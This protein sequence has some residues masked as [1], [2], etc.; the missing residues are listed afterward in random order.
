MYKS[1]RNL[2]MIKKVLLLVALMCGMTSMASCGNDNPAIGELKP[3]PEETP[4]DPENPVGP[5]TPSAPVD[6]MVVGY[7]PTYG[8]WFNPDWNKLTH[9][10]VAFAHM[11]ADGVLDCGDVRANKQIITKAHDNGV[12]VLIS[13]RDADN[14]TS[15][16]LAD[17]SKRAVLVDNVKQCVDEFGVEGVDVD[18][19]EW[20]GDEQAKRRNLESFYKELHAAL[21]KDKLVTAAVGGMTQTNN[22]IDAQ[23]LS[24]LDYVFPMI[25]DQCGGWAG[26]G[27]GSVG[28]HSSYEYYQ[29]VVNFFLGELNVPK[30][31]LCPGMPFYGYQFMSATSTKDAFAIA[32]RDILGKYS[33]AHLSDNK[34]LIWYNGLETIKKKTKYAVDNDLAGVMIWEITQDCDDTAKSL[35]NAIDEVYKGK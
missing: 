17:A 8:S 21:G 6:K 11:K 4:D 24:Q 12:K 1:I 14:S 10:C 7:Y 5:D 16:V 18:F 35:L 26:G 23:M 25:Y 28:Q 33:D 9:I 32:Y 29:D 34:G 15:A 22:Q 20:G 27:W 31:K 19:E 30:E 2:I 13:L 3:V